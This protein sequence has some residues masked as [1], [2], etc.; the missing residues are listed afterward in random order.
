MMCE[1][2]G[3]CDINNNNN[4]SGTEGVKGEGGS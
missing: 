4:Q 2:R 1:K 3:S